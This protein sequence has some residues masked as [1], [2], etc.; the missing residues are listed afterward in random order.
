MSKSESFDFENT[1]E[2]KDGSFHNGKKKP[3]IT[4]RKMYLLLLQMLGSVVAYNIIN[5][6]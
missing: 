1:I 4:K 2:D 3:E 5:K 6:V